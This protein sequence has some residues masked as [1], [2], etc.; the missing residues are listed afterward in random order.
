[1]NVYGC[2]PF[3][4]NFIR[5]EE[6][7]G[8]GLGNFDGLHL[9][10][11]SL[12]DEL[13]RKCNEKGIPSLVY[14]FENHPG[15]VLFPE[16]P[17]RLIV[18]NT[19]KAALMDEKGVDGVYFEQFDKEYARSTPEQFVK[20]ILVDKLNAKVVV[21]GHNYSFAHKGSG[22]PEI[23]SELGKKYGF[24]T[25]VI[26]PVTIDGETV[27]STLL[28]A[29]INSGEVEKYPLYTGRRYS[30]PGVV[31]QGRQVGKSLGFPTANILPREGFAIP[32]SG[33]Y[34]TETLIDGKL[35]GGITNIGNNPTFNL[36]KT[37]VET[38]L[39][40]YCENLYGQ[41]IEVFFIKRV[42]GEITF[43]SPEELSARVMQDIEDGKAFFSGRCD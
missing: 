39:F 10:H 6:G 18:T 12:I 8:V 21:T 16:K 7:I 24:E 20:E 3:A 33:V 38:H 14:T 36:T 5:P 1:M 9:G 2:V 22:T 19:Q 4:D 28:R 30:M 27:S 34:I 25:V 17:T 42:R 23:L 26:P 31:Q 32:D 15:N 40:D 37:T 35:Y 29:L 43:N 13:M 11:A 41:S